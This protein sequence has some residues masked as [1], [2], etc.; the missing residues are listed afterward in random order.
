MR[1]ACI[2]L[3][4]FSSEHPVLLVKIDNTHVELHILNRYHLLSLL[5]LQAAEFVAGCLAERMYNCPIV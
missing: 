3:N 2:Q 1:I 5:D 4:V